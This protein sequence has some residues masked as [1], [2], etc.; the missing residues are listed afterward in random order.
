[1]KLLQNLSETLNFLDARKVYNILDK[2]YNEIFNE[3]KDTD[4]EL[5]RVKFIFHCAYMIERVL[6]RTFLE[7]DKTMQIVQKNQDE[8]VFLKKHFAEVEAF[9]GIKIPDTEYV[10]IFNIL[11]HIGNTF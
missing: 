1:M 5:L 7:Y 3:L 9:F 6:R 8:F 2:V 4:D 10:F 11:K